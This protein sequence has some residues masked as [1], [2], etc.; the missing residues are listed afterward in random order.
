MTAAYSTSG[1]A[2]AFAVLKRD[3]VWILAQG[4]ETGPLPAGFDLDRLQVADD[5]KVW[6]LTATFASADEDEPNQTLLLVNGKSYG[7]YPE[8]TTVEYAETAGRGSPPSA[9]PPRRPTC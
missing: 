1:T 8:L 9:P 6:V 4:K 7:P 2:A 3:R 5:G